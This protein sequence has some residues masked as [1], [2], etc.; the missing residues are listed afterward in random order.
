MCKNTPK[1]KNIKS[2][3][4]TVGCQDCKKLNIGE[5]GRDFSN[6]IKEHKFDIKSGNEKNALF[7]HVR[8]CNHKIDFNSSK[9]VFPSSSGRKRH[10]IESALIDL[11]EGNC[12]NANKGFSPNNKIIS[13]YV[14]KIIR[15]ENLAVPKKRKKIH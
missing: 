3:I 2:G 1:A 15:F 5:T 9:L 11:H 7:V 14:R 8:D 13:K 12:L 6:R 10:I 4:Y